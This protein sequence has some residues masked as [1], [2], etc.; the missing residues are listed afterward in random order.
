MSGDDGIIDT[1][2]EQ[3]TE[4]YDLSRQKEKQR[5]VTGSRRRGERRD[6]GKRR[7]A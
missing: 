4:S 1:K 2:G 6:Q 7:S 3:T 5:S